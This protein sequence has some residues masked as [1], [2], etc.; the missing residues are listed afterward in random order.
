VTNRA[1][2]E[3]R[4][5]GRASE[6]PAGISLAELV[7]SL[8]KDPRVVAIERNGDIVPRARFDAVRVEAGDALE[9]VQFVQGG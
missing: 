6:V 7:A 9:V 2:V 1:A 5:N 4:L 3:I 8:G